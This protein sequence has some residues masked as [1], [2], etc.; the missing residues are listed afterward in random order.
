MTRARL[1]TAAIV[2]LLAAAGGG[3]ALAVTSDADRGDGAPEA[4]PTS[5]CDAALAVAHTDPQNSDR[6]ATRLDRALALAPSK[7]RAA[8]RAM[9]RATDGSDDYAAAQAT[10]TTFNTNHCCGCIGSGEPVVAAVGTAAASAAVL[11]P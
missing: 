10:F 5:Y 2:V 6:V 11:R 8:I 9:Q 3:A 4:Q 1:A 7:V